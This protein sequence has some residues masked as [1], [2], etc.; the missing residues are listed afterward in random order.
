MREFEVVKSENQSLS[1]VNDK[2]EARVNQL[3]NEAQ[4]VLTG[5]GSSQRNVSIKAKGDKIVNS[6]S[7]QLGVKRPIII[8]KGGSSLNR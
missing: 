3:K 2:L 6:N 7:I 5:G 1:L 8:K 4:S